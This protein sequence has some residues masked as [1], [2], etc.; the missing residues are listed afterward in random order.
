M[1]V[2]AKE[3]STRGSYFLPRT[4]FPNFVMEC[5]RSKE[6]KSFDQQKYKDKERPQRIVTFET[7]DQ[8]DEETSRH[9]LTNKKAMPKPKTNMFMIYT[10][11]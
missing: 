2:P 3:I 1:K 11:K 9:D 8:G 5:V 10:S 4:I 6:L 7:F